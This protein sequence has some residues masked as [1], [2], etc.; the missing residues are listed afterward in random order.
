MVKDLEGKMYEEKLRHLVFSIE[1]KR[2]LREE[3]MVVCSSSQ[4][5]QRGRWGIKK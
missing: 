5:E 1:E 3:L 4:V 2:K